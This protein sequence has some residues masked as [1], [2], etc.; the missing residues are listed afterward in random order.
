MKITR[1]HTP[2][3]SGLFERR[4]RDE[5]DRMFFGEPTE[6]GHSHRVFAIVE[7]VAPLL[8]PDSVCGPDGRTHARPMAPYPRPLLEVRLGGFGAERF[9]ERMEGFEDLLGITPTANQRDRRRRELGELFAG[10]GAPSIHLF[11]TSQFPHHDVPRD[12]TVPGRWLEIEMN[13]PS[14]DLETSIALLD[15][16]LDPG[17]ENVPL[18]LTSIS[19]PAPRVLRGLKDIFSLA[20]VPDADFTDDGN[21][22]GNRSP[23]ADLPPEPGERRNQRDGQTL[24]DAIAVKPREWPTE[25]SA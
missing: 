22:T 25:G 16:A 8:N 10:A 15:Q 24:I 2:R 4:L 7:S 23:P 21:V 18:V 19:L 14:N 9:L 1:R 17:G 12:L 11:L 5:D 3:R 13:R 20:Y 6:W